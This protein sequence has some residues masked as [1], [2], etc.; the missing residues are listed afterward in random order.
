MRHAF[1]TVLLI[2]VGC[3]AKDD[4]WKAEYIA[5]GDKWEVA[6]CDGSAEVAFEATKA[7]IDHLKQMERDGRPLDSY[8]KVQTWNY[9]RFALLADH[10]G[11]KEESVRYFATAVRYA[12][13]ANPEEPEERI[14]EAA[15]RSY[16]DQMDTPDKVAWRRK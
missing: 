5:A 1:L 3:S 8:A 6:Y 10:L 7:F 12:R 13:R 16:L 9:A 14:S 4:A 2:V 11:R 15:F